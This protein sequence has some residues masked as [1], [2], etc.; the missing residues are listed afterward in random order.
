MENLN[1]TSLRTALRYQLLAVF[2]T[3]VG[4]ATVTAVFLGFGVDLLLE[5]KG[6]HIRFTPEPAGR[7]SVFVAD[8]EES[9]ELSVG[10]H[11]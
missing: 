6:A 4:V 7:H 11:E 5:P 8:D 10:G 3:F 1:H 2:I 9:P